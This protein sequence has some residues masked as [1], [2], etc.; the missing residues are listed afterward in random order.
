[1]MPKKA[2]TYPA[3][4][5]CKE[6]EGFEGSATHPARENIRTVSLDF[7]GEGWFV[8]YSP[9][10]YYNEHC[11]VINKN[12]VPMR[13][14]RKTV[15]NLLDFVDVFPNYMAG[16]NAALPIVG[17]S[18]LNHEHYQGGG[19]KMPMQKAKVLLPLKAAKYPTVKVGIVDWYN[20]VVRLTSSDRENISRLAGDII[21]AWQDFDAPECDVLSH[22]GDVPH[23]TLSPIVRFENGEYIVDMILRNNRT[24]EKYPVVIDNDA[25]YTAL[26][27]KINGN[28]DFAGMNFEITDGVKSD[29][30]LEGGREL[31]AHD[32]VYTIT[33]EFND[34][35]TKVESYLNG[36]TVTAPQN[37]T[38][39]AEFSYVWENVAETAEQSVKYEE[40][41]VKNKYTVVWKNGDATLETDTD[42]EYGTMPS[43]DGQPPVKES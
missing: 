38:A 34:G 22:T 3:C 18:I 32:T 40:K 33:W 41:A 20:S 35:T 2:T 37:T 15:E 6:N 25:D 29:V 14:T 16:S 36:A 8:Q 42:V 19:H 30:D 11:I 31:P 26:I 10:A 13:I 1:S 9:Y 24:D 27:K 17:G 43:Y 28:A 4:L 39:T 7:G 5:L 21:E 23:N 12:H